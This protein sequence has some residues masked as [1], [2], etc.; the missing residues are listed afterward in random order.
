M[1]VYLCCFIESFATRARGR[2]GGYVFSLSVCSRGYP[3]SCPGVSGHT[4]FYRGKSIC[5]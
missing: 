3:L 1:S 5:Y 2:A 4:D